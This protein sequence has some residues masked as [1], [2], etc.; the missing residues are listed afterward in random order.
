MRWSNSITSPLLGALGLAGQV[1]GD[2]ALLKDYTGYNAGAYGSAPNQTYKSSSLIS[3]RFQVTTW[4]KTKVDP[5][6]YVFAGLH[7]DGQ[8]ATA[9]MFSSSDLSLVWGAPYNA[10]LADTGVQTYNGS[11]VIVVG[12]GIGVGFF[13][14]GVCMILDKHYNVLHNVSA[15]NL[16]AGGVSDLH[17]CL[18]TADDTML[19]TVYVSR[20]YDLSS[21]GGSVNDTIVDAGFQEVDIVTGE[22]L[23]S[24]MAVDHYPLTESYIAYAAG[25]W[26]WFH[27]NSVQK[28]RGYHSLFRM[29]KNKPPC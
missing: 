4:D 25:G 10:F 16:P 11:Q 3:P 9:F 29:T 24:W 15:G 18:I 8:L 19:V 21:I 28:V 27:V 20:S 6:K 23:F 1:L 5:A 26:D 13:T 14:S 22:V 17:E 7:P 12:Q 2:A